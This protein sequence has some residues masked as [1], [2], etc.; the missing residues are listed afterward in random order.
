MGKSNFQFGRCPVCRS[1]VLLPV[2]LK[3]GGDLRAL[4]DECGALLRSPDATE[5]E[6]EQEVVLVSEEPALAAGWRPKG[7]LRP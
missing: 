5:P 6:A 1:G 2:V 7:F 4:C 3:N